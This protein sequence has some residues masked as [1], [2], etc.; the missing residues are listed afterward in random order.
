M[1]THTSTLFVVLTTPFFDKET[2]WPGIFRKLKKV[3]ILSFSQA[4]EVL[5]SQLKLCFSKAEQRPWSSRQRTGMSMQNQKTITIKRRK[6]TTFNKRKEKLARKKESNKKFKG[7][8][9]RNQERNEMGK[10]ERYIQNVSVN[11]SQAPK[12]CKPTPGETLQTPPRLGP[13]SAPTHIATRKCHMV[14][15]V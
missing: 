5:T 2:S 11:N 15:R 13:Y 9:A 10:K 3:C 1:E 8:K 14:T 12:Y 6:D 7:R 4:T